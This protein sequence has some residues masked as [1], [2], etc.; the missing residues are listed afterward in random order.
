[1]N[2]THW[3]A[4]AAWIAV[5]THS[6][7]AQAAPQSL[8]LEYLADSQCPSA[9][10]FATLV[11]ERTKLIV[12]SSTEGRTARV[13]L[14]GP[15]P[16]EVRGTLRIEDF[17]PAMDAREVH[18]ATCAEVADAL[19]FT[20]ALS[21]DPN[22][23]PRVRKRPEVARPAPL[24]QVAAPKPLARAAPTKQQTPPER[25]FQWRP[26]LQGTT[27]VSTLPAPLLGAAIA[28][29][30]AWSN[31]ATALQLR[32]S[33]SYMKAPPDASARVAPSLA[34][35]GVEGCVL[36]RT[37]ALDLGPCIQLSIGEL[38]AKGQNIA[39]PKQASF[40]WI[41]TTP[42]IRVERR[43][44]SG[45]YVHLSA[46]LEVPLQR[47]VFI[48]EDPTREVARLSHVAVAL[49]LGAGYAF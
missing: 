34:R 49:A 44:W 33:L 41:A 24:P 17:G 31:Q 16:E 26:E 38:A 22:A 13:E 3:F 30:A 28:L 10:T 48:E 46:M 4:I 45:L 1:M 27:L 37:A 40:L 18:G 29:S 21:I 19:A 5:A 39:V 7:V 20:L 6:S 14:H 47:S 25:L 12:F 9:A 36:M 35:A 23:L 2:A 8:R 11:T 32:A 15:N 43:L 42:G